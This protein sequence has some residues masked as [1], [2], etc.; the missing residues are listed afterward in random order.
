LVVRFNKCI[1]RVSQTEYYRFSE[2][3]ETLV[4]ALAESKREVRV[5]ND[6]ATMDNLRNALRHDAPNSILH[7]IDESPPLADIRPGFVMLEV[8]L[9][10]I[11]SF[12]EVEG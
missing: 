11:P 6:F 3:V 8:R 4:Q 1:H 12:G 2:Q 7:W 9:R 10:R 5:R